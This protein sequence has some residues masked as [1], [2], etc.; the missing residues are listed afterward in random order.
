VTD[1]EGV[2]LA[3][4]LTGANAHD[5]T[6]LLPLVD[7]IPPIKGPRGRPR[8]RPE[9]VQGDRGY[10]SEPH[11]K[12][13]RDLGIKP[14]IARQRQPHGSGLGKTRWVVERTLSW[15]HQFRRLRV[16]W[17]RRKDIHEAFMFIG[18]IIIAFRLLI[19]FC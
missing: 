4:Q 10:A 19:G 18:C 5:V 2:P 15:L 1:G 17:E 14:V 13:L 9:R 16:R 12:Q 3:F 7:S 11:K 8:R 6:Q